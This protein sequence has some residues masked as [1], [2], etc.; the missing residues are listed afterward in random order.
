MTTMQQ[1]L[2]AKYGYFL[3]LNELAEV[4]KMTRGSLYKKIYSGTLALPYTKR[5]QKYLF[6][7]VEVAVILESEIDRTH[8]MHAAVEYTA[9]SETD[10]AVFYEAISSASKI[11]TQDNG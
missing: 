4:L 11:L 9:T 7:A 2:L 8:L 10:D 3:D 6:P 5:A 1:F